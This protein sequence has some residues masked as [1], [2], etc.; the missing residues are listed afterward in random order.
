MVV[1][2]LVT[3]MFIFSSDIL[4]FA[5]R[6]Y[7]DSRSLNKLVH[8]SLGFTW[9]IIFDILFFIYLFLTTISVVLT[10][11]KTI[12]MNFGRFIMEQWFHYTF[13]DDKDFFNHFGDFH[14]FTAFI[15]GF[16]FYFLAIQRD[17]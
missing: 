13:K 12:Y 10:V 11:S 7:D 5:L 9:M 6:K 3:S 1:L 2:V 14:K 17:I 4:V 8:K 16:V 15:I